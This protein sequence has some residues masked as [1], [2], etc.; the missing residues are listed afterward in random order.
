MDNLDWAARAA[1]ARPPATI[2]EARALVRQAFANGLHSSAMETR[3]GKRLIG[4]DPA[5]DVANEWYARIRY[6]SK[7]APD[8]MWL[9]LEEYFAAHPL[10]GEMVEIPCASASAESIPEGIDCTHSRPMRPAMRRYLS[11]SD[12]ELPLRLV[13]LLPPGQPRLMIE[14]PTLW[15]SARFECGDGQVRGAALFD[16]TDVTDPWLHRLSPDDRATLL[17]AVNGQLATH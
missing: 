10:T 11:R 9:A 8:I 17:A 4:C 1:A 15:H 16:Q 7:A 2:E 13:E 5:D 14:Q 12:A 3:T 6:A